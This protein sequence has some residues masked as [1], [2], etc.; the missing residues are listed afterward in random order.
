M[1]KRASKMDRKLTTPNTPKR[2]RPR[3]QDLPG[4]EDR[5]IK[6]LEDIAAAYADARDRRMA[7][8]AEEAEL[9]KHALTL[10]HKYDKT[11]YRHDGI[12]IR[13]VEGEEDVKVKVKKAGDDEDEDVVIESG[14]TLRPGVEAEH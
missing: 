10:M 1:A 5:A 8:N 3:A 14:D 13:I 11:I 9:K 7:L 4:L 2:G 12:E 6:P